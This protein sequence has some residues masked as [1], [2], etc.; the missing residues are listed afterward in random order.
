M[1][2]LADQIL[3]ELAAIREAAK[4]DAADREKLAPSV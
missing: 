1:S 4:S 2:T 3:E